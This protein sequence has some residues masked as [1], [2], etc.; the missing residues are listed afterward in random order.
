LPGERGDHGVGRGGEG[1]AFQLFAFAVGG[2]PQA[3]TLRA[4][5]ATLIRRVEPWADRRS[6]LN[7][8]SP[9]EAQTPDEVRALYGMI[10]TTNFRR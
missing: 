10:C 5:L 3:E 7:F 8:L 2:P 6:M 4:D 9:D 1:L